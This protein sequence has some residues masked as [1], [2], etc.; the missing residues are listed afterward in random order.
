MQQQ[1][2][3]SP[4]KDSSTD[5]PGR[6]D[7]T[8]DEPISGE[9]ASPSPSSP[10]AKSTKH[11]EKDI[12]TRHRPEP[13]TNLHQTEPHEAELPTNHSHSP[14]SLQGAN[15]GGSSAITEKV[16]SP[17]DKPTVEENVG[18]EDIVG[19]H[20]AGGDK[21]D[22]DEVGSD[23]TGGAVAMVTVGDDAATISGGVKI[24]QLGDKGGYEVV[25]LRIE[26]YWIGHEGQPNEWHPAQIIS[27]NASTEEHFILYQDGDRAWHGLNEIK[28]RQA[29]SGDVPFA[30]KEEEQS[31]EE[32]EHSISSATLAL[33]QK[34]SKSDTTARLRGISEENPDD[35]LRQFD[36][37]VDANEVFLGTIEESEVARIEEEVK[38]AMEAAALKRKQQY[39]ERQAE[40]EQRERQARA[41]VLKVADEKQERLAEIES[42]I[43]KAFAREEH[44]LLTY[45]KRRERHLRK[46]VSKKVV[47]LRP[48]VLGVNSDGDYIART[49]QVLWKDIPIPVQVDV[50]KVRGIKDKLPEGLFSIK[51]TLFDKLG[52]IPKLPRRAKLENF[53]KT[54]SFQHAGGYEDVQASF[55]QPLVVVCENDLRKASANVIILEITHADSDLVVGWV[56]HSILGITARCII[57]VL[58]CL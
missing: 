30:L 44:S 18:E 53:A 9:S 27:Y 34:Q 58:T 37:D 26:V 28:V 38:K 35:L 36:A 55:Q 41:Q 31:I 15:A 29:T 51:A 43:A 49:I 10:T 14:H 56:G 23:T 52:G 2:N 33:P 7:P 5:K 48:V 19:V 54:L 50:F 6:N 39:L 13:S 1:G 16:F 11:T 3:E 20:E 21:V 32:L 25:G 47:E 12:G 40:L 57:S 17:K 8:A 22:D 4:P 24:A 42:S 45:F 46:S